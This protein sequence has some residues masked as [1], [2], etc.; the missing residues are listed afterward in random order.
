[1][2]SKKNTFFVLG[3]NPNAYTMAQPD[4]PIPQDLLSTAFERVMSDTEKYYD[5]NDKDALKVIVNVDCNL[6]CKPID[7]KMTLYYYL[8]TAHNPFSVKIKEN[9][10]IGA[11][12]IVLAEKLK[13]VFKHFLQGKYTMLFVASK[14]GFS[15]VYANF[16]YKNEQV[17]ASTTFVDLKPDEYFLSKVGLLVIDATKY[18][19]DIIT[20]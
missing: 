16:H 17:L 7:F 4:T 18:F 10:P 19:E 14:G 3:F 11:K 15:L 2:S 13:P 8:H 6:N 9:S 20:F 12:N 1:M 5:N